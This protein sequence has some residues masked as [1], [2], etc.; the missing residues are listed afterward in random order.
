M[1]KD[2]S[3]MC[4]VSF[5]G[6][7]IIGTPIIYILQPLREYWGESNWIIWYLTGNPTDVTGFAIFTYIAVFVGLFYLQFHV[8]IKRIQ[9]DKQSKLTGV[10]VSIPYTYWAKTYQQERPRSKKF[11]TGSTEIDLSS[12]KIRTIDLGILDQFPDL[13]NLDLS[14]NDLN[15]IDLVPLEGCKNLRG[16]FLSGNNLPGI[17]LTPL[18]KCPKL[19]TLFL[20]ENDLAK[21][22]L[23]PLRSCSELEYLHLQSND[24]QNLDLEPLESCRQLVNLFTDDNPLQVLDITPLLKCTKFDVVAFGDIRLVTTKEIDEKS[25]PR[26]IRDLGIQIE[27]I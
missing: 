3:R 6:T 15:Q 4:L 21:I 13:E 7:L 17:D 22:D 18:S 11:D 1:D 9:A 20:A 25:W 14:K 12:R 8:M 5:V 23:S 2:C 27:P 16:L 19:N 24:L 10:M 26:A